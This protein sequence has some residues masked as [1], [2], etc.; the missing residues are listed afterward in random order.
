MRDQI[1]N[2]DYFDIFIDEN[3]D[4]IEF[5]QGK[6]NNNEVKEERI[7]IIKNEIRN[8]RLEIFYAQYSRGDGFEEIAKSYVEDFKEKLNTIP[9]LFHSKSYSYVANLEI[10]SLGILLNLGDLVREVYEP[11]LKTANINDWLYDFILLEKNTDKILLWEE[12]YNLIRNLVNAEGEKTKVSILKD[13][14]DNRWYKANIE[15]GWYDS[16]KSKQDTYTG[17]WSLESG[18]VA[19]ILGLDDSSLKGQQYYPYDMVHFKG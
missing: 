3:Q 16:H 13:Y 19:K 11:L 1:K 17:Y 10:M 5:Y 6:L 18:A 4:E 8:I 14:L 7:N 9:S 2:K 12:P 15:V